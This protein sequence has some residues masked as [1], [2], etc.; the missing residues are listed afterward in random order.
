ML[1]KHDSNAHLKMLCLSVLLLSGGIESEWKSCSSRL[2][3]EKML[4]FLNE[5]SLTLS[6]KV[7]KTNLTLMHKE[8]TNL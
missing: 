7:R 8:K 6:G 4:V 2:S 3:V 1:M 5:F